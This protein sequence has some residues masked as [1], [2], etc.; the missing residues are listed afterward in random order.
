MEAAFFGGPLLYFVDHQPGWWNNEARTDIEYLP[1]DIHITFPP[2]SSV[3]EAE[4]NTAIATGQALQGAKIERSL[5]LDVR[6]NK[7]DG[8]WVMPR[9]LCSWAMAKRWRGKRWVR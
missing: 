7:V 6:H 3:T 8:L 2:S 5:Y 1:I 9:W 4:L